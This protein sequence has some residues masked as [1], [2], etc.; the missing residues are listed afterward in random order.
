[1]VRKIYFRNKR[2]YNKTNIIQKCY[3]FSIVLVFCLFSFLNP[4]TGQVENWTH[5]RGSKLNGIANTELVPV[6]F[7]DTLNV[8]WKTDIFGR[9]WSSPVIFGDQVWV[10]TA[11][12]D[13]KELF[14]V[15]LDFESGN[16]GRKI[17]LFKPDSVMQKHSLNSYATPTPCIE[18]VFV[19]A[20]F[21]SLGTACINTFSGSAIC[22]AYDSQTCEEKWRGIR[23]T[24]GTISMPFYENGIIYY[25][26]G[27]L[28]KESGK[29]F[30]EILAVNPDGKGNITNSHILWKKE[31]EPLQILTPL[32]KDGLI[33]TV[34]TRNV[35]NCIDSKTSEMIWSVKLTDKYNSSPVYASGNIY[36]GSVGGEVLVLREGT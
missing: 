16:I 14:A 17:S 5:F 13:G 11:T 31:V 36:I 6:I 27:M 15:N 25:Y 35:L 22:S 7:N 18:K 33:Y 26:T 9:G 12:E 1:M 21:G 3:I 34:D 4:L 24:G 29:K 2:Y 23:G 30:S 32:I 28:T 20:H 19:Y 8:K 10:T